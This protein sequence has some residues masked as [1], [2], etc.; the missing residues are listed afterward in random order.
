MSA[1]EKAGEID[2]CG[3]TASIIS[4]GVFVCQ[5]VKIESIQNGKEIYLD[6]GYLFSLDQPLTAEQ[7]R[8][9]SHWV[10]RGIAWLEA[11]SLWRVVV[12]SVVLIASLL[13]FRYAL[14]IATPLVVSIFP[15]EWERTIGRNT[16]QTLEKTVLRDTKLSAE[17]RQH[18]QF[19]AAELAEANGFEKP[20][21]LFHDS[22]LI[23]ANALAFPG[24]PVVVTDDLVL[25]LQRDDLILGVIAH[26]F[27]HV[28]QKHSLQQI[29]EI[30]G[31]AAISSVV[32]GADET[33]IEEASAVGLNLWASKKSRTFE[34]EADLLAVEYMKQADMEESAFGLAIKKLTTHYCAGEESQAHCLEHSE[35]SWFSSHPS[36]AERLDYLN[37]D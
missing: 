24:G 12:L 18:L 32:F 37:V 15:H 1:R 30:I 20:Q 35:S 36:G 31:L 28:Q 13:V 26:E 19:K 16:Y 34:M 7:T 5:E 6:N 9:A 33:L 29:V 8:Q 23:G 22:R 14:T 10:S 17:R 27:A 4:D 25:L 11:F 2:L 3:Q 21:L